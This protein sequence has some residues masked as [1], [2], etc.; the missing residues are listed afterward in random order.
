MPSVQSSLLAALALGSA[1][2]QL[3]MKLDDTTQ[4]LGSVLSTKQHQIC[5]Q[6]L[7]AEQL[8]TLQR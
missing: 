6:G 8:Q 5:T 3:G 2:V 7:S 4:A 1:G